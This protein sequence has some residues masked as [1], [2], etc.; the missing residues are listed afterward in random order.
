MASHPYESEVHSLIRRLVTAGLI[1]VKVYDGDEWID[2]R[3]ESL[4][5]D[6]AE[7]ILSVDDSHLVVKNLEGQRAEL[8]IIL[9]NCPG[10]ALADWSAPAG[11]CD[12]IKAVSNAHY[13]AWANEVK[14]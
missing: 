7:I 5:T 3:P 8:A 9:G 1:P 11:I 13:A 14:S 12:Q 10:E 4:A 2:C 6:A